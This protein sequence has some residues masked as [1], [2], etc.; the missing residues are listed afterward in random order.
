[1]R[2]DAEITNLIKA[3]DAMERHFFVVAPD[4]EIIAANAFSTRSG[5]ADPVGKKCFE[6]FC[7]ESEPCEECPLQA[8]FQQ[9][10]PAPEAGAGA[11]GGDLQLPCSST[12]P[13]YS[14]DKI[15]ALVCTDIGSRRIDEL[16]EGFQLA[17]AFLKNLIYSSPDAI[18]AADCEG[19][20]LLFNEAAR[21]LSGYSAQEAH[22]D[23]NITDFYLPG[24]A[25][26]V[27]S[28][29][30]SD[31][32]G[33]KGKLQAYHVVVL[34]KHARKIPIRLDAAIIYDGGKEVATIG[35]FRDFS[36][37]IHRE[38]GA[39]VRHH[40]QKS[41]DA[42]SLER[43]ATSMAQRLKLYNQQFSETA[44]RLG[45]IGKE[46]LDRARKHQKRL[47]EKTK[48]S[49][50]LGRVLVQLEYI[51]EEQRT[52]IIAMQALGEE[53]QA[54]GDGKALVEKARILARDLAL[55]NQR[56]GD[57]AVKLG[58]ISE[59]RLN[60]SLEMQKQVQ[61]KIKIDVPMG[62][63]MEQLE[64]ITEEQRAAVL[65][66]QVLAEEVEPAGE[67]TEPGA[68]ETEPTVEK[69]EPAAAETESEEMQ[70]PAGDQEPHEDEEQSKIRDYFSVDV[71]ED[72]L[73]ARLVLKV[74]GREKP[75][76]DD[77]RG[78]IEAAGI[79]HGIIEESAIREFIED[80][81]EELEP[82]II[83]KGHPPGEGKDP[84]RVYHFETDP[85]RAGKLQEDG[86][87]D[88]KDR[89]EIPQVDEG[90]FLVE[91]VPGV[92]GAVGMDVFGNEIPALPIAK[93]E[94][95]AGKGVKQS[96]D[97]NRFSASAKGT[98]VL[99]A[100][101]TLTVLPVLQVSG[102]IG[103]ETGHVEFDGHIEVAGAIQ[104]GYQVRGESLRAQS[105]NRAEIY[106]S[107]DIV[108]AGGIF[109]SKIKCQGN[110]KAV[111]VQKSEIDAD[112]DLVVE[113]EIIDSKIELH[114][115]CKMEYGTIISSEIAAR[116]GIIAQN[117]GTAMSPPSHLDVGVDHKLRREISGLKRLFSKA[118]RKKKELT[119]QI[120]ALQ[121]QSDQING[122]L[123]EVAQKQDQYMVQLRQLQ[124]KFKGHGNIDESVQAEYEKAVA[125]LEA[126]RSKIDTVVEELM[127]KD[128]EIEAITAQLE[129]QA[130]EAVEEQAELE[131]RIEV[132]GRKREA[133]KGK[134]VVKVSGN[135]FHGTK[136][137]GPKAKITL[138]DDSNHV[139]I[140]ET[141]KTDDGQFARWH[142]KI[143]PLR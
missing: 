7:K 28:R 91:I 43:I 65:A 54:R 94:L 87:I 105:I 12:Y 88:W 15:E 107:S 49:V 6:I 13:V 132:L 100:D 122:E 16:P 108:V 39:A 129:E 141:D 52:A 38:Q 101:D 31:L 123:G 42:H 81:S 70:T 130:T 66:V 115:V 125:E 56:F 50:S 110:V 1:M 104:S 27:M 97:G 40:P 85:L 45:L 73:T 93:I 92:Y 136:I 134:P 24:K 57:L 32:Y 53:G 63:V 30:R 137:T 109:E 102:D 19:K 118:G 131:E 67:G 77:V 34:D 41:A 10:K 103:I 25:R 82:L 71:S 33:G 95:S 128:S 2:K 36:E 111:H 51:T 80:D 69:A 4:L 17:N 64:Y 114:G 99:S 76:F 139:N 96:K 90:A 106:I 143:G 79:R 5:G 113:K 59:D 138:D 46:Q 55:Y 8:A 60:K 112:G 37:D 18:I 47:E 133:E 124:E 20:I 61:R 78:L 83:A 72:K 35:Y 23:Y 3:I 140:Y 68:G 135:I 121:A 14:G 86:T 11:A 116:G 117:V 127:Q 84:E 48:I 75:A 44:S 142:M 74:R 22:F 89:G 58:F 9:E 98:P 29:L 62:R 119:P 120:E 126:G 21:K 26:D